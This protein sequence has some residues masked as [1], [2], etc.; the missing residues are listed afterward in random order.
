MKKKILLL[1]FSFVFAAFSVMAQDRVIA[2]KVTSSDDGVG[3]PGVN[4][5]LKGTTN[6]AVTTSE[7]T[8]LHQCASK[9]RYVDVLFCGFCLKG[10]RH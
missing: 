10:C 8:L 1:C 9:W 6:G 7:G 2:G 3:L 4:I 5:L